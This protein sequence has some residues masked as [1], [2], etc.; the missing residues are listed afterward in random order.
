[1]LCFEPYSIN[2]NENLI[3]FDIDKNRYSW[4]S[5]SLQHVAS[6]KTKIFY[7]VI[8]PQPDIVGLSSFMQWL[9]GFRDFGSSKGTDVLEENIRKFVRGME[10]RNFVWL[11]R[12]KIWKSIFSSVWL[13]RI[14]NTHTF[15]FRIKVSCTSS[16]RKSHH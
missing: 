15:D 7:L 10:I 9:T 14:Q 13:L 3:L 8:F 1:M 6:P 5:K 4:I 12:N 16:S 2:G 11:H